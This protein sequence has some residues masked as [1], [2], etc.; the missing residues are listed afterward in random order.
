MWVTGSL[1]VAAAIAFAIA[2]FAP[3]KTQTYFNAVMVSGTAAVVFGFIL[4]ALAGI[5][6]KRAAYAEFLRN[7]MQDH[8]RG[9][10][11]LKWRASERPSRDTDPVILPMPMPS[12]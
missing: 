10:Y 7:C 1:A 3:W 8:E 12:R 4:L 9:Q 11:A 2:G 5:G 6:S